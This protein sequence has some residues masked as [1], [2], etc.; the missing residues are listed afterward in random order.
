MSLPESDWRILAAQASNEMDPSKLLELV[1]ELNR[2]LGEH[3]EAS[4]LRPGNVLKTACHLPGM[5]R[6]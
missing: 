6:N 3:E 1:D 4:R 5:V 2:A